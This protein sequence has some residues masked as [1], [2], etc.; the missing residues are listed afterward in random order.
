MLVMVGGASVEDEAFELP[1]PM[2]CMA[3]LAAVFLSWRSKS[4]H[5]SALMALALKYTVMAPI[6][7]G[8]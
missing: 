3:F 7:R 1:M 5:F 2:D 6:I 8:N 4:D